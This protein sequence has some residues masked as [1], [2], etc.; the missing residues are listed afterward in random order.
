MSGA[1]GILA[2]GLSPA[3]QR[4]LLFDRFE[5]GD[6]NR[7]SGYYLDAAG[8]CVNVARVLTQAGCSSTCLTIAGREN[9]REFERL[10]RRDGMRIITTEVSGRVRT[11]TTVIDRSSG[12]CTEL[13]VN[14]PE[15]V[16]PEE[17][18]VFTSEFL[19]E[20]EKRPAVLVISGSGCR[21]SQNRSSRSWWNRPRG[22]G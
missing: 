6:V 10:C 3:L 21:G 19:R 18:H 17:K 2:V 16:T 13:V 5:M 15:R 1:A 22:R 11:C 4:S 8:K 9:R 14:E 7:S 20:L 12:L